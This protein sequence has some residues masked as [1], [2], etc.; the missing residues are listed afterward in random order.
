MSHSFLAPFVQAENKENDEQETTLRG[1]SLEVPI[2]ESQPTSE[3]PFILRGPRGNPRVALTFDDGPNPSTTEKIL[4]TLDQHRA[5]A[6]FFMIGSRV[7]E[8]PSMAREVRDQGHDIGNHS[9]THP[10]LTRLSK[11]TVYNE[12][13]KTQQVIEDTLHLQPRWF[14]PPYGAFKASQAA[15]ATELKLNIV[16]WSVDP[17]DWSRPG[18]NTIHRRIVNHTSGGDIVLCHDIHR[19]TAEAAPYFIPALIDRG[20]ELVT[21][22]DLLLS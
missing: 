20:F 19:Q 2:D 14:R 7:K 22:S 6:T 3:L 11:A 21:L 12:V 8:S 5:K 4:Q 15:I 16:I 1:D 13:Q 10:L 9:Y 18:V 17:R